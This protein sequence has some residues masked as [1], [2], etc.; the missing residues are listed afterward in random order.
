MWLVIFTTAE[1]AMVISPLE[2]DSLTDFLPV[3]GVQ[4]FV[5]RFNRHRFRSLV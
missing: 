4:G 5:L 1:F 2:S 3:T